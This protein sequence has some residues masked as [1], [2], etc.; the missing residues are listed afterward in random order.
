MGSD[1]AGCG[2]IMK[3]KGMI[4]SVLCAMAAVG[5]T[6][7]LADEHEARLRLGQESM[8]LRQQLGRLAG[9]VDCTK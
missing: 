4:L 5:V 8:A 3:A 2:N 1:G 9:L 6:I 7:W